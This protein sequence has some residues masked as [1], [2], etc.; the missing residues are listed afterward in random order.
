MNRKL[1]ALMMVTAFLLVALPSA[2]AAPAAAQGEKVYLALGDSV[3]QGD[4]AT[5]LHRTAYVPHLFEFFQDEAHSGVNTLT[6]LARG[7]ATSGSFITD[8]QLAGAVNVIATHDIGV[9]TLDIGGNDFLGLLAPGGPCVDPTSQACADAMALAM[10]GFLE[11]YPT[12]VGTLHGALLQYQGPNHP[13]LIVMTYYNPWSGTGSPYE[14][15][16][17]G[18]LVGTDGKVDCSYPGGYGVN[19]LLACVGMQA[20][21]DTYADV[22]PRFVG[23]GLVLTHIAE[24][25]NVHP[26]NAGHAQIANTFMQAYMDLYR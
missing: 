19:D 10:Y 1:A 12:I 22:Y 6:N 20:G 26:N 18:L 7:G 13:P 5:D 21:A 11:N 16:V 23:K 9:V 4:G 25:N 3:A 15:V 17:D 14:S 8:G 24:D 2:P